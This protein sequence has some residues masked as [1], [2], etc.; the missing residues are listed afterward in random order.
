MKLNP[1]T[2]FWTSFRREPFSYFICYT[3]LPLLLVILNKSGSNSQVSLNVLAISGA[4]FS[5]IYVSFA[6]QRHDLDGASLSLRGRLSYLVSAIGYFALFCRFGFPEVFPGASWIYVG[7]SLFLLL[8]ASPFINTK[9]R[10]K[11]AEDGKA[12]AAIS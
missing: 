9:S 12:S 10:S 11:Q 4:V 6:L 5:S 8:I 1:F 3:I 2:R 7:V